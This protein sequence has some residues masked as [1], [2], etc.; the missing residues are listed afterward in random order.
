MLPLCLFILAF[1]WF[2]FVCASQNHGS[3]SHHQWCSVCRNINFS[4]YL[5]E[6]CNLLV[7][8]FAVSKCN[9]ISSLFRRCLPVAFAQEIYSRAK[10]TKN[11]VC[12]CARLKCVPEWWIYFRVPFASTYHNMPKAFI[13]YNRANQLVQTDHIGEW[14][15]KNF[16]CDRDRFCV[17]R[18]L[19]PRVSRYNVMMCG[20]IKT[21]YVKKIFEKKVEKFERPASVGI[22]HISYF[23]GYALCGVRLGGI[24][25]MWNVKMKY[26][27]SFL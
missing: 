1:A 24:A 23:T 15:K 6:N 16:F 9:V 18:S 21:Q 27:H 17:Y 14:K 25:R 4:D 7:T 10:P 3:S 11:F 22:L 20:W 13:L 2:W 12:V 19:K 26:F 8:Q 5:W